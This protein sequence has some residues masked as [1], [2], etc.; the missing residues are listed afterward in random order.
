MIDQVFTLPAML[1][2]AAYGFATYKGVPAFYREP[3]TFRYPISEWVLRFY[4]SLGSYRTFDKRYYNHNFS[5]PL[6]E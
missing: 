1:A 2:D 5:H 6:S 3:F 4:W